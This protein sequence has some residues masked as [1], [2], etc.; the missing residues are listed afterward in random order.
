M[1]NVSVRPKKSLEISVVVTCTEK[2]NEQTNSVCYFP[3]EDTWC[4]YSLSHSRYVVSCHGKIYLNARTSGDNPLAFWRSIPYTCYRDFGRIL[5]RKEEKVF[6]L[7]KH[8]AILYNE[9]EVRCSACQSQ[10]PTDDQCSYLIG[11]LTQLRSY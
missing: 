11:L 9:A 1:V 8:G 3:R 4:R 6:A 2:K 7:L 5:S 10:I